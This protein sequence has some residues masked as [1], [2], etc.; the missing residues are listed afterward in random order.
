MEIWIDIEDAAGT[1]Y[2]DGPI[3]TAVEWQSLRRLDAAGTFAFA[4]P[5]SDPRSNL[6]RNKRVARCWCASDGVIREVGAG[7]IDQIEIA[8]GEPTMLRVSGDDLLRELANRTVGDLELFEAVTYSTTDPKAP[9]RL[10]YQSYTTGHDLTLPATVDLSPDPLDFLYVMHARTFSKISLSITAPNTTLS[11]TF[12][13][14]YY[15]AQDPTRPTWETLGGVVNHTVAGGPESGPDEAAGGVYP[16]GASG[17]IEFDPPPGWSPLGGMYVIRFFDPTAN[18]TPFTI[19]AASVTI[20]EPVADGLQRIMGLAPAGWSLDPAG[21]FATSSSVY[22]GFNGESVLAALIMLA[23]Q[24]GEHFTVSAAG[25]RVWWIGTAQN[26]SGLRAAQVT[27]PTPQTLMLVNLTRV[28]DS[29]DLY[30]RI[31]PAGG[32]VGSGRATMAKTT[33]SVPGFAMGVDGSYLEATAAVVAFGRIDRR[34]DYPDIAPVNESEAQVVHAANALFERAY[35]DLARSSQLQQVYRLEVVPSVYLVWPGQTIQVDYHEWA[36]GYHAVD[37]SATL[38]V[39]E[40]EQRISQE[41]ILT[42]GL[43]VGTVYAPA[44]N[45]DYHALARLMGSVSTQRN[46]D[47]PAS[48]YSSNGAGV[49]VNLSVVNGQVV[50][51]GRVAPVPDGWYRLSRVTQVRLASGIVSQV[52]MA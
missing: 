40:V 10:R 22:M 31:Y 12:Q 39:L 8:P 35:Q 19:S 13:I 11:D 44:N 32:G 38:H 49:P 6:L 23:E 34:V 42:V 51:V 2:G 17:V 41:G 1:R 36:D 43:T 14:Q 20:I 3:T 26:D 25:R 33:L 21:V 52:E 45:N 37:I 5:A 46:T 9:A 28:S 16:F 30:T 24:K 50:S 27:E 18:L 47:T 29:Y 48:S 15:N 7:I 4:M